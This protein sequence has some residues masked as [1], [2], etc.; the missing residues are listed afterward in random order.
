M[1]LPYD[2]IHEIERKYGTLAIPDDNPLMIKLHKIMGV[3]VKRR[4]KKHDYDKKI[5]QMIKQGYSYDEISQ[6]VGISYNRC[7]RI[8]LLYG[9][10][11]RPPFKY[12]VKIND[13]I[14]YLSTAS[15]LKYFGVT[16]SANPNEVYKRK[17][18]HIDLIKKRYHWFDVPKGGRYMMLGNDREILVKE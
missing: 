11:S 9:Y 2:L 14:Y 6:E 4:F 10:H 16:N 12:I 7:Q 3:A 5:I 1:K 13:D 8:V 15:N 18:K 17:R